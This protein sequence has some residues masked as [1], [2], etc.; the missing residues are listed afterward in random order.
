[1]SD[2]FSTKT[3]GL[4][5]ERD[6]GACVSCGGRGS[7]KHHRRRRRENG[8]GLAH[9]PANGVLLCGWGNHSGCHGKVHSNPQWGRERGYIVRPGVD[10]ATVR[11]RHFSRGWITLDKDGGW[12]VAENGDD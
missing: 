11:L 2:G 9:T 8:D 10:P 5:A 6:A 4:I 1:M 12:K 7:E 3:C